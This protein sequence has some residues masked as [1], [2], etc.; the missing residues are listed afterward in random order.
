[1]DRD[2]NKRLE[3]LVAEL[4]PTSEEPDKEGLPEPA[5]PEQVE[6][7]EGLLKQAQL[8][9]IRGQG[10]VA[11]RLLK[12]AA[13]RAPGSAAVQAALG[14][15]LW[16][17][18]QFSRARAAYKMAHM[19]EP[20]NVLYE[21]KWA[22]SLVGSSRDPSSLQGDLADSYAS[23]K[24][25]TVLSVFVP[26]LGQIVTGKRTQGIVMLCIWIAGW[27]YLVPNALSRLPSAVGPQGARIGEFSPLTMFTIAVLAMTWIWSATSASSFAKG[28][29]RLGGAKKIDRPTPPGEGNF[30]L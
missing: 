7:A 17:R 3:D 16:E 14:D 1:M 29:A 21:T 9:K 4:V 15:Q 28:Q 8:A 26:G 13:E 12:E 25:A 6:E 24:T 27:L 19:L 20:K 22:E 2:E 11:E 23:A 10:S 5:T 30:E 18:S